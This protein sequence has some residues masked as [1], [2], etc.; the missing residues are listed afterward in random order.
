LYFFYLLFLS[1]DGMDDN[2][3]QQKDGMAMGSSVITNHWQRL[4]GAF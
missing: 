2:F 3:A 4:C 1:M